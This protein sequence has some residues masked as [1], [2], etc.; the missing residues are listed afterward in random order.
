MRE[1]PGPK[2]YPGIRVSSN[3]PRGLSFC[4]GL[5]SP[6]LAGLGLPGFIR[7]GFGGHHRLLVETRSGTPRAPCASGPSSREG[8]K[9]ETHT[10]LRIHGI[11]RPPDFAVSRSPLLLVARSAWFSHSW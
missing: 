8:V 3:L 9:P 4:S 7:C 2:N 5:E 1:K 6:F 10:V 11:H